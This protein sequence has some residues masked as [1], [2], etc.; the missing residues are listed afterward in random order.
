[1]TNGSHPPKAKESVY[2]SAEETRGG[3]QEGR[4]TKGQ[5]AGP[6]ALLGAAGGDGSLPAVFMLQKG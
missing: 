6:P 2:A 3:C 4:P 5:V 1:M